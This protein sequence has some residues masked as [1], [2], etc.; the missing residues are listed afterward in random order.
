MYE[1]LSHLLVDSA[2]LSRRGSSRPACLAVKKPS[3]ASILQKKKKKKKKIKILDRVF[4]SRT[5][6]K[7]TL[8]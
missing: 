1:N 6:I 8:P 5:G 2:R 3:I 7:Y 4:K